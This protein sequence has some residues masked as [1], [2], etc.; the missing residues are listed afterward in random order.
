[1]HMGNFLLSKLIG[2]ASAAR[3]SYPE[4]AENGWTGLC[5]TGSM[6]S[7]IDLDPNMVPTIHAPITYK[8][9]FNGKFNKVWK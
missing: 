6:Q 8:N 3:F 2:M 7:P 9:Y 1:M 5:A 4:K